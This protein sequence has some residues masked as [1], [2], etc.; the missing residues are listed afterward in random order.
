MLQRLKQLEDEGIDLVILTTKNT[1]ITQKLLDAFSLDVQHLYGYESGSKVE[2][3][4]DLSSERTIRGF[5]EDRRSTLES[6]LDTSDINCIP[7]YLASWG[8]L[9]PKDRNNLPSGISLLDTQ[10][11][12]T[13]LASWP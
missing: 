11:L 13:P 4:R 2:I 1:L 5:I 6:V 10:T 3:L 12:A 9:R 7:C 8:Y